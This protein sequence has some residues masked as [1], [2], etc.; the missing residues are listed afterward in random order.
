MLDH[1][2]TFVMADEHSYAAFVGVLS[3]IYMKAHASS[4]YRD[5]PYRALIVVS[6]SMNRS[7][8]DQPECSLTR[9]MA[10]ND[11]MKPP[12]GGIDLQFYVDDCDLIHPD[13]A[14]G[15]KHVV[16]HCWPIIGKGVGKYVTKNP[17]PK[18]LNKGPNKV[19]Y[20]EFDIPGR[21]I[22]Y[23]TPIT[24]V[25]ATLENSKVHVC[26]QGG[27]AWLSVA[28]GIPTIIVHAH[29]P[30]DHLHYKAKLFGQD[31]NINVTRDG[32]IALVRRHPLEKHVTLDQLPAA[33]AA[34]S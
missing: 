8:R 15:L 18:A 23:N 11:R 12:D 2:D 19:R 24:D 32:K 10:I 3:N 6:W 27:T 4:P 20:I 31:T 9:L 25:F 14:G 13:A 5:E 17:S 33:L 30:L 34:Y 1:R 7:F 26:Y 21:V 29:K 28:M 16:A 22:D